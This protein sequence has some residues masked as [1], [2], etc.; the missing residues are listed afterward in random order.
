MTLDMR[1]ACGRCS[2]KPAPQDRARTGVHERTF[3]AAC[4][5]S[6]RHVCPN[7]GGERVKRPRPPARD[8]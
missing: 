6:M 5:E 8:A 3:G 2:T 1:D 4:A 7:C